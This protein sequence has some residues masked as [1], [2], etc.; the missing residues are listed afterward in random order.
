[1]AAGVLLRGVPARVTS[2]AVTVVL[3]G[4][5]AVAQGHESPAELQATLAFNNMH[6]ET[7]YV[8]AI[9]GYQAQGHDYGHGLGDGG[10]LPDDPGQIPPD[11]YI[12]IT[13]FGR[14]LPGEQ[15]CGQPTAQDSRLFSGSCAVE[16]DGLV[17]RRNDLNH[18]YQIQRG[19]VY[20][21]VVG[22]PAVD[23]EALR[24]AAQ[25]VRLASGAELEGH[26]QTGDYY[27]VTVPGYVGHV[28]GPSAG[29][30]YEPADHTGNG[31][32][33][34]AIALFV[35]YGGPE[36]I[37][38]PPTECQPDVPGVTFARTEDQNGYLVTRD[39]VTVQVMGGLRVDRA[40]LRQAALAARPATDAEL[41]RALPRPP[42]TGPNDR[43]R[44]WFHQF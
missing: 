36:N 42:Q 29:M 28:S 39:P 20:V 40:L 41:S 37:C 11:R 19:D 25:S 13:A 18:G 3:V 34:V 12:T 7:A 32:R 43:L 2:V 9:P 17:Y 33:T 27:A 8:V 35:S 24:A 23:H 16:P 1:L 21:T 22:T 44:R 26:E 5:G 31:S 15:Q 10:F 6:R 30:V 14:L 38:L 4:A